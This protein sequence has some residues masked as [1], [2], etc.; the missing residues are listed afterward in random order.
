[1][2]LETNVS[3]A[4]TAHVNFTDRS[5]Y[6]RF[7]HKNHHREPA[8]AHTHRIASVLKSRVFYTKPDF[9]QLLFTVAPVLDYSIQ[10]PWSRNVLSNFIIH[11]A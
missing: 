5:A 11:A 1:M 2:R 4:S 3:R 6:D 8:T 9:K 10:G 7:S